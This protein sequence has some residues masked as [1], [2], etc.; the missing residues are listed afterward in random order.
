MRC[1][2]YCRQLRIG[3]ELMMVAIEPGQAAQVEKTKTAASKPPAVPEAPPYWVELKTPAEMTSLIAEWEDVA[4]ETVEANPFYEPWMLQEALSSLNRRLQSPK[5]PPQIV[6]LFPFERSSDYRGAPIRTWKLWKHLYCFHCVPLLRKGHVSEAL[7]TLFEWAAQGRQAPGLMEWTGITAEGPFYQALTDILR[8]RG[9]TTFSLDTYNRAILKPAVDAETYCTA[10]MT[11]HNR[12]E[13]RRQRRRLEE[14]GRLEFRTLSQPEDVDAWVDIF[15]QME[16]SG[17]KGEEQTALAADSQH[18]D[19]FR[20]I[21]HAAFKRSQL[22]M[23]GLFLDD[24]PIAAKC[25]FKSGA[26]SFAFKIGFDES[27]S[28][29]SP[30]V[31][32]EL[33][34]IRVAHEMKDLQ[35]MDSCAAPTHFMIN[36]LWKDRRTIQKLLISTGRRQSELLLGLIPFWRGLKKFV[37]GNPASLKK[38]TLSKNVH[39]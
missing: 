20:K 22:M 35:W 7:E 16:A 36:R 2:R 33:E 11:G 23:L 38:A 28:K 32:L 30:G 34:N 5:S 21:S 13:Q 19:Y 26:G 29:F 9:M 10:G 37:F 27:L 15:L 17:W 39:R 12:Q 25:N 14:M 4:R 8:S 3:D 1:D 31:Q 24:R 18:A 6:G